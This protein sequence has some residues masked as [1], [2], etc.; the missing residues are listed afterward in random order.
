MENCR[1]TEQESKLIL[2]IKTNNLNMEEQKG[3][4]G[5]MQKKEIIILIILIIILSHLVFLFGYKYVLFNKTFYEKEFAKNGV[6]SITHV[7][8][9]EQLNKTIV[10]EEHNNVMDFLVGK[11]KKKKDNIKAKEDIINS[12]FLS[13]QDKTHLNDVRELMKKVDYYS[14]ILV[15]I[16]FGLFFYLHFKHKDKKDCL[17]SKAIMYSGIFN[18]GLLLIL[19]LLSLNFE[20]FFT[21]FHTIFF[22]NDFWLMNP[23]VDMLVNLY[24]EQFWID[25]LIKI[26]FTVLIVSVIFV[27]VGLLS[28]YGIKK[29][30]NV[31]HKL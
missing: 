18:L 28:L 29:Q 13:S 10:L 21:K 17:F 2:N 4:K 15:L 11:D 9:K 23:N 19:Y 6:Y 27:M 1:T 24:P 3:M 12:T 25:A 16:L 31:I 5:V 26:L 30:Q 20:W 22:N 14:V 8:T 7:V